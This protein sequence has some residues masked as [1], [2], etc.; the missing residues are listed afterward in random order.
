[1][2][3]KFSLFSVLGQ[4]MTCYNNSKICFIMLFNSHAYTE[5]IVGDPLLQPK[6]VRWLGK[7]PVTSQAGFPNPYLSLIL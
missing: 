7:E 4:S 1:M 2:K 5:P 6:I 3:L